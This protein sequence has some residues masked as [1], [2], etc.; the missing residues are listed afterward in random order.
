M[1]KQ[2]LATQLI[3]HP[4]Q[5]PE[6][7]SAPQPAVHKASSI[8]LPSMEEARSRSPIDHNT[9]TYGTHGTPTSHTLEQRLCT[10]EGGTHA[11]LYPNGLAAIAGVHLALLKPDDEVLLPHHI[12]GPNKTLAENELK[13]WGIRCNHYEATDTND[14]A[15]KIT[16]KTRLVWLEAAGS[17]TLEFPDLTTQVQLCQSKGIL[18]ALDSTWGA[19]IAYRPFDLQR[20]HSETDAIGVDISVHAL[21]KY[22]S[23]GGNVLMGSVITRDEALFGKLATCHMHL[24]YTVGMNDAEVILQ[25]LS[26]MHLRY[27]ASDHNARAIAQWCTQQ[28]QFVQVLHPALPQSVGH[29]HWKNHCCTPE[30]PEGA[31]AGL[32]SVIVDAR[33]TLQQIDAFCE[34]LQ[35]F[36]I[37]YSWGG[38]NSLVMSYDLNTMRNS[39]PKHLKQG[40]LVRFSTGLEH[41]D[42]L[43]ADL[44]QALKHLS[45]LG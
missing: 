17:N 20:S 5:A 22:P 15:A 28:K 38:P 45:H 3:N 44:T 2:A 27:A 42:D 13:R 36:K 18:T 12:Y 29:E 14:L 8:F 26:H 21:T 7:F 16:D 32:V 9:Y 1:S 35:L 19:G 24:G 33:Y 10:L 30:Q 41:A 25:G 34:S 11:L 39:Y 37:A 43:L 23:G 40:T 31:A 6:G 4:Y